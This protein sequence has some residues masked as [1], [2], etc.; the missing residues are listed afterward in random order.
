MKKVLQWKGYSTIY[1]S[2]HCLPLSEPEF[3]VCATELFHP[4]F[5]FALLVDTTYSVPPTSMVSLK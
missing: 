5:L 1:P 2:G 4:D 3:C